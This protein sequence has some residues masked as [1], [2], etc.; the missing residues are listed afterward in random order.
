MHLCTLYPFETRL[1]H[2]SFCFTHPYMTTCHVRR[3]FSPEHCLVQDIWS[4]GIAYMV[5]TSIQHGLGPWGFN[6]L[7]F[8][9]R[10]SHVHGALMDRQ[11]SKP[12]STFGDVAYMIFSP[13]TWLP[14]IE[15]SISVSFF[16]V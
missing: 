3:L 11:S 9:V 6:V 13:H 5:F 16:L 4:R 12:C 10:E 15:F 14:K 1:Y 8:C 7:L 2:R